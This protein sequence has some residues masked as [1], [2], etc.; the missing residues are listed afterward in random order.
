MTV[1]PVRFVIR[2][3]LNAEAEYGNGSLNAAIAEEAVKELKIAITNPQFA[4][5]IYL[6]IFKYYKGE[7]VYKPCTAHNSKAPLYYW[8]TPRSRRRSANLVSFVFLACTQ[9]LLFVLVL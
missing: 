1:F 9:T 2:E 5:A 4:R 7:I 6:L 8:S 3:R